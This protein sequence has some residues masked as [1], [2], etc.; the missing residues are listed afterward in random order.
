[1][2]KARDL[3]DPTW[4]A[5]VTDAQLA[6]AITGGKGAMPAFPLP[7]ETVTGLVRLVRLFDMEAR[8]RGPTSAPT[9]G[10]PPV[11]STG[12]ASPGA[13]PPP[14]TGSAGPGTKKEGN[15]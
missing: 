10:T 13:S 1:M 14:S 8:R 9:G 11:P 6:A 4:Q 3:S 5:S 12:S 7:E 2:V 15:P